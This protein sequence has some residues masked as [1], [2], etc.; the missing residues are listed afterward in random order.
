MKGPLLT[1]IN[2][3]TPVDSALKLHYFFLCHCITVK[4]FSDFEW[5]K[6]RSNID[7]DKNNSD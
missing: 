1:V 2:Q 6:G 3:D 5:H 7:H 4:G